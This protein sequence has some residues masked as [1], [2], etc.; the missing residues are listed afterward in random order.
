MYL[1]IP[2]IHSCHYLP[3]S[4][5]DFEQSEDVMQNDPVGLYF[6]YRDS[7]EDLQSPQLEIFLTPTWGLGQVSVI[8]GEAHW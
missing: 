7:W 8:G 3:Q 2:F 5:M 6:N 1:S 4:T